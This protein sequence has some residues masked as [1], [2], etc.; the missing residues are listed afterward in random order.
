MELAPECTHCPEEIPDYPNEHCPSISARCPWSGM[1]RFHRMMMPCHKAL[2]YAME[3][4]READPTMIAPQHGSVLFRYE[5][6]K[7]AINRLAALDDVGID[8]ILTGT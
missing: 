7:P 5:D 1:Y 3:Q 2:L 6:L 8:G 4:V